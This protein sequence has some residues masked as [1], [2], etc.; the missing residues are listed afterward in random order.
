MVINKS[1]FISYLK[2]PNLLGPDSIVGLNEVVHDYPYFQ[3]AQ[4]LLTKSYHSSENLNFESSLKKTAAY[5]ANRKQL[6]HLLFT[7]NSSLNPA[8]V[9]QESTAQAPVPQFEVPQPAENKPGQIEED[10]FSTPTANFPEAE[11][12]VLVPTESSIIQENSGEKEIEI[13]ATEMVEEPKVEIQEEELIQEKPSVLEKAKFSVDFS[14]IE[15]GRK[16]KYDAL[17]NQ[18]LSAAVSSSILLHVSGDIPDI[19]SLI[20]VKAAKRPVQPIESTEISEELNTDSSNDSHS[21]TGWLRAMDGPTK[22]PVELEE[23]EEITQEFTSN[24]TVFK[25]DSKKASFYSPVKMARL[26]VQEDDDLMTETLANI[27]A[28]QG[29]LEKA[30]KAFDKLKLKYPEKSSYFAGRI[31]ELQIQLNS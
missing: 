14:K 2:D 7:S 8:A 16:D 11:V 29:H 30:I 21:F 20:S 27:Y 10:K 23:E 18:I 22:T 3:S 5:A 4:M 1:T 17:E 31:K 15:V 9:E 6:H 25:P 26:S 24:I 19:D 13:A 12:P 28:D